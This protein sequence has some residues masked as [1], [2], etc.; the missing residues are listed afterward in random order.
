MRSRWIIGGGEYLD[1]VYHAW[2]QAS[3]K[4]DLP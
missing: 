1:L 3:P 2:K 4:E